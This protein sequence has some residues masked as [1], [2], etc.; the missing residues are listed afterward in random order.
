MAVNLLG[1]S[2]FKMPQ[3]ASNEELSRIVD[4]G[5]KTAN[6]NVSVP[7]SSLMAPPPPPG[8]LHKLS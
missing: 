5:Q 8:L 1:G 7:F 2:K 4:R 6:W 3:R